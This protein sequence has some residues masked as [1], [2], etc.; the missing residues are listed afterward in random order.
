MR[1]RMKKKMAQKWSKIALKAKVDF[2]VLAN[3]PAVRSG[4]LAEEGSLDM[5]VRVFYP[6]KSRYSVFLVGRILIFLLQCEYY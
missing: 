4:V 3:H 1:L 6:H 2:L 5:A